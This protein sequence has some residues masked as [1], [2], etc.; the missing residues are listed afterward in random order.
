MGLHI[1]VHIHQ[2]PDNETKEDLKTILQN[3]SKIMA[4]DTQALADLDAIKTTL[5]KVS[6]ESSASLQKISELE[7]VANENNVSQAVLDKIA[8]VKALAQGI[9][10]LVPDVQTDGG[11][12]DGQ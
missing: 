5:Q 9:D 11:T 1:H 3:Q 10:E 2:H 12:G 7:A 6:T 8:E 4:N